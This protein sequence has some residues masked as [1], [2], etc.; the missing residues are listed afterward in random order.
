MSIFDSI[1]R[2]FKGNKVPTAAQIAGLVSKADAE[3]E[4]AEAEMKAVAA[5]LPDAVLSGEAGVAAHREAARV[6]SERLTYA[7]QARDVLTDKLAAAEAA[8]AEAGRRSRYDTAVAAQKA[9]V[10]ELL[11]SYPA[12]I[13][14]LRRLQVAVASADALAEAVNAD[15]PAGAPRLLE[16]ECV[17]DAQAVPESILS[18]EFADHWFTTEGNTPVA[19]ERITRR[20]GRRGYMYAESAF[21]ARPIPCELRRVRKV[22]RQ[23]WTPPVYGA[24]LADLEL[25]DLKAEPGAAPKPVEELVQ[26]AEVAD[27][28]E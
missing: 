4:A 6:A 17:R 11:A 18:E 10:A 5:R 24:R 3:V 28:A 15:L 16:T 19:A 21:G 23:P 13:E 25:P 20:E 14:T 2:T 12:A 1:A 26:F 22:T 27:A 8:E 9:A 7:R